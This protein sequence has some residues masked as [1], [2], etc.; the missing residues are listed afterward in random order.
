MVFIKAMINNVTP[1]YFKLETII[2][3]ERKESISFF[4][5]TLFHVKRGLNTMVDRWANIAM[6]IQLGILMK[7]EKWGN[8]IFYIA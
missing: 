3:R 6:I 5:I 8:I 2:A 7:N 4:K 1:S